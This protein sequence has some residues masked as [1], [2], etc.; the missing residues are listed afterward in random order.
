VTGSIGILNIKTDD[1]NTTEKITVNIYWPGNGYG[2]PDRFASMEDAIAEAKRCIAAGYGPKSK[3][4]QPNE[5][6]I[7]R[8]IN[9]MNK[10][11]RE[12]VVFTGDET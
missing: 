2:I 6:H 7:T 12:I 3:C 1:A 5:I 10:T 8:T 9:Q 11:F 4:A